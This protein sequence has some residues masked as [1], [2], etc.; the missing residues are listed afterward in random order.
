MFCC[1]LIFVICLF[2][3]VLLLLLLFVDLSH[4]CL[5]AKAGRAL[6]KLLNDHSPKLTVLDINDNR[7]EAEA[8]SALGHALQRNSVLKELNI[9]MN[10]LGDLG[11]QPLLKAL[12]KN[13]T[14]QILDISSNN[15]GEPSAPALAEVRVWSGGGNMSPL[16]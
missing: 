8:G 10:W 5:G 3:L 2:N 4:N 1:L 12:C 6:G 7:L 16:H 11:V 15:I 13:S 9:S 14:L